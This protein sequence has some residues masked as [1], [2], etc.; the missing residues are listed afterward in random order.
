LTIYLY[1]VKLSGKIVGISFV[2]EIFWFFTGNMGSIRETDFS[3][4]IPVKWRISLFGGMKISRDGGTISPPP[5]RT[6][7]LLT[8]LLL[9]KKLPVRRE[10]LAELLYGELPGN[11][12]RSRIS[13]HLWQIKKHLPGFPLILT[14]NDIGLDRQSIWV[15]VKAF[16]KEVSKTDS[17]LSI[18]FIDL[19][20]GELLPELYDDWVLI[21][22][23]RWRS[24]YLRALRSLVENLLAAHQEEQ[25]I[26]RMEQLLREEPYDESVVRLLMKIQIKIGRRGAALATFEQFHTLSIEQ[27]GLE[28]EIETQDLYQAIYQQKTQPRQ[29]PSPAQNAKPSNPQELLA[30]AQTFLDQGDRF[31]F[32]QIMDKL[33]ENLTSQQCLEKNCLSFD[34]KFLWGD[35]D[36]AEAILHGSD[37]TSPALRLRQA[38]LAI[39]RR[40]YKKGEEII[41]VLLEEVHR[42]RQPALEAEALIALG[43]TKAELGDRPEALLILD[44]A[45]VL[46][47]KAGAPPVQVQAFIYKGY[48]RSLRGSGES[49]KE[50]NLKAVALARQY[51]LRPLL[52]QGLHALSVNALSYGQYHKALKFESES[53]ELA[54]DLRLGSLEANALLVMGGIFDA[55]GRY[56]E[57]ADAIR[58]STKYYEEK[59]D[60]HGLAR[61]FYNLSFSL[62]NTNEDDLEEALQYAERAL[63]IFQTQKNLGWQASTHTALGFLQWL[64]GMP[65]QAIRNFEVAIQL[66]T[67]LEEHRFIA[68]NYAYKG[69]AYIDKALP[70]TAL[71]F[72]QMAVRELTR[73]NI[74]D[75]ASEIYYAHAIALQAA[76]QLEE[77]KLYIELG[78]ERLLENASE[79]EDEEA[80]S[81]FF[82]RDPLSRKLMQMAYDYGVAPRPHKAVLAR[83]YP[84]TSQQSFNLE[85]TVDAGAPDQALQASAGNSALRRARLKRILREGNVHGS[86]L[87]IKEMAQLLNVSTRTIQRDLKIIKDDALGIR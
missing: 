52:A 14:N 20:Q 27:L 5:Y 58:N 67:K 36:Q 4:N 80:R 37:I 39:A 64:A 42:Y 62:V 18:K 33:P 32:N 72:T 74:S 57:S 31:Q 34:E 56:V 81:A 83:K 87:T 61:C 24:H 69:L 22:R 11:R 79:I 17:P 65:D 76:G 75:I 16:Q 78:Y 35:L 2:S 50:M 28:P 70:D 19:Y 21:E 71:Q 86:H 26:L 25:A 49:A 38:R 51:K 7:G 12:S 68:E 10:R 60:S 84:G 63:K 8:Y 59:Q 6:Y 13:D 44:R 48:F 73:R 46:A 1:I 77:S 85:I 29:L 45:I 66:H 54:R 55:L 43:I 3:N 41:D 40:E 47:E 9:R 82:N 53:L 23:E 30:Q 15:D